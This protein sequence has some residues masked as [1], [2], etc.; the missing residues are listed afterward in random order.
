MARASRVCRSAAPLFVLAL[1]CAEG[2]YRVPYVDGTHV[3]VAH[4]FL[5]HS[6]P[7]ARMYDF[8]AVGGF[9]IVAAA[10]P[11]WVRFIEDGHSENSTSG[12]IPQN[13]VW[14]EHPGRF[15]QDANDPERATWPGKSRDHDRT[16]VP[17]E[18]PRGYCNEWTVYAHM[19]QGSVTGLPPFG[20]GLAEGD[21]IEAGQPIGN[22]GDVG[23][24]F[25]QHLHWFVAVIDPDVEPDVFGYYL[26][27]LETFP[28]WAQEPERIP[29]LCHD[30]SMRTVLRQGAVVEATPCS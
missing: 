2:E 12:S 18:R 20:A 23:F 5:T 6:T 4:D 1:A 17:C 3:R 9:G 22:E 26:D 27:W 24:A 15:C 7:D 28:E 19:V 8:V 16:C 30:G 13:Y 10:A 25:G 21:W 11:G 14:I 29:V